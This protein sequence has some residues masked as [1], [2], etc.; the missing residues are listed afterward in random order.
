[1][2]NYMKAPCE[3]IKLYLFVKYKELWINVYMN[4]P[5]NV[6]LILRFIM[7]MKV[8]MKYTFITS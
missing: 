5:L 1:M 6:P 8:V 4:M 7:L 2:L 3:C